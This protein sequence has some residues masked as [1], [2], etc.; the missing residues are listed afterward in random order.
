MNEGIV[1]YALFVGISA[2]M[3]FKSGRNRN[4]GLTWSL[5]FSIFSPTITFIIILRSKKKIESE[6]PPSLI[7]WGIFGMLVLIASLAGGG[8]TEHQ[9]GMTLPISIFT[10]KYDI[11]TLSGAATTNFFTIFPF[12]ALLRSITLKYLP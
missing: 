7:K 9:T 1:F 6:I 2:I 5:I 4:I 3:A 10:Q 12:Y 8:L 11:A